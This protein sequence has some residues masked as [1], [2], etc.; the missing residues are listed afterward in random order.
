MLTI[1]ES[2]TTGTGPPGPT[3]PPAPPV[4]RGEQ[5][6]FS[7]KGKHK[8][9]VGFKFLF[10]GAL[11]ANAAQSTGNY[12]VTQKH[13]KK[14]KVL[15]VESAVDDP[16]NTSVTISVGGFKTGKPAQAV[17]TGLSGSNGAAIPKIITGL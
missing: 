2:G 11:D 12:H 3:G 4:F 7:H 9:L 13:G 6:V 15:T 10:I 5:R 17:I 8:K 14:V 16:S 1:N